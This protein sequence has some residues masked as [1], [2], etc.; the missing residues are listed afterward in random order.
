LERL[1][2]TQL[3]SQN[4]DAVRVETVLESVTDWSVQYFDPQRGWQLEWTPAADQ[5]LPA[6]IE[7][8]F[9]HPRFGEIRRLLVLD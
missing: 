4:S 3:H 5:P 7:Y 9:N 8:G 6:A 2:W 1:Y